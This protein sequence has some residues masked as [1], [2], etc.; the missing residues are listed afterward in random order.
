MKI[1][2]NKSKAF[3]KE[4]LYKEQKELDELSLRLSNQGV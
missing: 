1:K 2:E 4:F 3:Y